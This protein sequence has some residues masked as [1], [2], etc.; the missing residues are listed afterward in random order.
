MDAGGFALVILSAFCYSSLPIFGKIAFAADASLTP[1]LATRFALAA[2]FLWGM[3][4][5]SPRRRRAAR[6]LDKRHAAGL[7][8]WGVFGYAGQAGIFFTALRSVS[9]SMAVVLLY[10]CPAFLALILWG[11][12]RRR[13][14]GAQL[15]AIGLALA[16]VFLCAS[17]RFDGGSVSGLGLAVL[18]GLWYACFLLMLNRLTPGVPGVLSGCLIITGAAL[19]FGAL[20]LIQGRFF[21]PASTA[22]W[23]SLAGMIVISTLMAFVL[24]INGL[25]RVG[26]QVAAILS[27]FEPLGTLLIAGVFLGERLVPAQIG[28]AAMII[29]AAFV[30]TTT[31]AGVEERQPG[32]PRAVSESE[33]SGSEQEPSGPAG[34]RTGEAPAACHD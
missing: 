34:T 33:P 3:V 24:F 6:R 18:A 10:T 16:G 17:P 23:G 31:L 14:G 8:L 15:A 19:A 2:V 25:K 29:G 1:L 30:L 27:T 11:L 26:P 9:A 13:P 28:G 5:L 12:T 32:L 4:L 7:L 20:A 22:G 21:I